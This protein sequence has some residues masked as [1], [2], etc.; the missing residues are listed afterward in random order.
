[1]A[2][3]PNN[4]VAYQQSRQMATVLN[5]TYHTLYMG[6]AERADI[7][8]DFSQ[9]A[10][11]TIIMYND[12]PAPN[13]G[14]EPRYDYYTGDLDQTAS[15]G[16]PTTLP[17]YGPNTRTIIQ[18]QVA[19][20]TP[21]PF[22]LAALQAALPPAYVATQ[23]PPIVPETFY[24]GAYHAATDTFGHIQS[25]SLTFTPV[26]S[27]P[28]T[29]TVVPK[30]IIELFDNYGRM[31]AMLGT[32]FTNLSAIPANSTGIGFHYIDP[33]T[34]NMQ[35]GQPQIWKITHNGVD[36]H[37]IHIHL[38]NWQLI[39]RVGWDGTITPPN[40]NERGW[41]ET[42]KMNPLEDVFVAVM[43]TRPTLPFNVPDSIRPLDPSMALGTTMQFTNKD[44]Q[45]NPITVVNQMYNF[46]WEFM[47]HCHLL[48]HED[49]DMMR[50][51]SAMVN[52]G[53]L[54]GSLNYLLLLQ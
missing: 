47:W 44:A 9:Y 16:A 19:A 2:L 18:F 29:M 43:A 46:H 22:N 30:S 10:G 27:L 5:V 12:A 54:A 36:T 33:P 21:V 26:G 41:K 1:M 38:V 17:G 3:I 53:A 20:A 6:P 52:A 39:N 45:G 28:T 25:E 24:P 23:P 51:I 31:N 11:K 50:P 42:I 4:P 34:E 37:A 35:W 13:P 49:N 40:D 8:I 14:F 7:I 32:E 15:G 48:G